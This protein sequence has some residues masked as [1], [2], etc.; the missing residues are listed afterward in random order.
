[1]TRLQKLSDA[2][3]HSPTTVGAGSIASVLLIIQQINLSVKSLLLDDPTYLAYYLTLICDA[4]EVGLIACSCLSQSID[5][6]IGVLKTESILRS[7]E[8]GQRIRVLETA[9]G[10]LLEEFVAKVAHARDQ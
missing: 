8:S 2:S 10:D 7:W 4:P 1:M 5:Q 3:E 9:L 6:P